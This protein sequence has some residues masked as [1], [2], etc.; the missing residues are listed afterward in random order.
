MVSLFVQF[1][2]TTPP[3]LIKCDDAVTVPFAKCELKV[4]ASTKNNH[5]GLKKVQIIICINYTFSKQRLHPSTMSKHLSEEKIES[6]ADLNLFVEDLL[7]QM[8]HY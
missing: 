2:P 8:V 1:I 6:P 3:V 5:S 4:K 7:E